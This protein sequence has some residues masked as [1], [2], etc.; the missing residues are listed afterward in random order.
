VSG[1]AGAAQLLGMNPS[2]LASR[3]KALG[4][5]RQRPRPDAQR[6]T[7]PLQAALPPARRSRVE[8]HHA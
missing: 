5:Q 2:T 6:Q 1:A 7:P 4:L 3:I 8:V